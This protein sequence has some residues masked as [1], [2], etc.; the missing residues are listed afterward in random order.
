MA[1][2][3]PTGLKKKKKK[4]VYGT[5]RCNVATWANVYSI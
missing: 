2:V 5:I 4:N 1:K 3:S